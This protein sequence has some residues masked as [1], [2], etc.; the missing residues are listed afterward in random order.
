MAADLYDAKNVLAEEEMLMRC[1]RSVRASMVASSLL[2]AT[3]VAEEHASV[4]V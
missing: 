3:E 1:R 4:R 2:Q